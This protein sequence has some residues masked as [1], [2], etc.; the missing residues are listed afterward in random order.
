M[1]SY[2]LSYLISLENSED[3]IKQIQ[4]KIISLVQEAGGSLN[5]AGE[6]IRKNKG[7]LVSLYFYL[8]PEKITN[9]EKSLKAEN[10]I[11]RYLIL[12]KKLVKKAASF[13]SLRR[14][15]IPK[16]KTK[17]ELKEIEKKL[18][19]ILDKT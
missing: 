8:S 1:K 11:F 4:D 16:T 13:P 14:Q 2:Q 12:T 9:L 7:Y 5:K 3:K 18:T 17:V 15:E 6:T 10:K 19:E